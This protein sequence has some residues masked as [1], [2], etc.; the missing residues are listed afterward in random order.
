MLL[1][2]E[3]RAA[4]NGDPHGFAL[5]FAQHYAGMRA[6]AH[7]ILGHGPDAEDACQDAA[8]VALTRIGE[9]RDPAAVR[10][11]LH[12]I[13][14]NTCRNSLRKRPAVPSG[15]DFAALEDP[16][17]GPAERIERSVQRDWI[18]H[19]VGRLS[20]AVRQVAMLRWFTERNSYEQIA[21]LCGIPVGTV[22][23]RLSE[24]RRQLTD[25]L[26]ETENDRYGC[27][28]ALASERYAEA[29]SVLS[30][31][32]PDPTVYDRWADDV[33]MDWS[34]GRRTRGIG[35]LLGAAALDYADGV[36]YRVTG[37]VV[38][39]DVT[40]WENDFVN[41]PEDPEHC[42]PAATWLLRERD[43]LVRDV[44]LIYADRTS[45]DRRVS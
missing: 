28:G 18:R 11:W 4:Q 45:T 13:V 20:P 33:A 41:P 8:V 7:G 34:G 2:D 29:A 37:V 40:V 32:G 39:P 1:V 15:L 6:V 23:S 10:P 24:A 38:G 5:L 3:T 27:A 26:P 36:T 9:L 12:A 35:A 21:A 25:V 14:R 31:L 43:G 16:H 42:P 17:D 22:R 30:G 19:A 44:R